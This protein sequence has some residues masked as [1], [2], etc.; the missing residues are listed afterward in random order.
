[1]VLKKINSE[2]IHISGNSIFHHNTFHFQRKYLNHRDITNM[3]FYIW[4]ATFPVQGMPVALH[5]FIILATYF[6]LIK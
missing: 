6:P 2:V 3:F 1:M 5:T 4:R